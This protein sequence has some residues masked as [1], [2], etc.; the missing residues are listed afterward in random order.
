LGL[1]SQLPALP[2]R[3]SPHLGAR[4]CAETTQPS[5]TLRSRS[6]CDSSCRPQFGADDRRREEPSRYGPPHEGSPQRCRRQVDIP[7]A[8]RE[9]VGVL[10]LPLRCSKAAS[11]RRRT[12]SC[13]SSS[14]VPRPW[15]SGGRHCMSTPLRG[16]RRRR[17]FSSRRDSEGGMRSAGF[18]LSRIRSA[19]VLEKSGRRESNPRSQLGKLMFCL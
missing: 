5:E 2:L 10:R 18:A 6:R 8:R 17:G 11:T 7:A 3:A 15:C 12:P 19:A 4:R 14:T 1:D 16:R 9:P 13:E